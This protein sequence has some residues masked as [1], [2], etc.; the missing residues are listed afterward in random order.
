MAKARGFTLGLQPN[1]CDC[2]SE[3]VAESGA[4]D[5]F[6]EPAGELE[7]RAEA[8]PNA[9]TDAGGARDRAETAD[10][11]EFRMEVFATQ[12]P[13]LGKADLGAAA[14][15]P[16]GRVPAERVV[17]NGWIERIDVVRRVSQMGGRNAG[18]D[19]G[20]THSHVGADTP[21]CGEE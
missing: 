3:L 18:A 14:D 1:R 15:N 13:M 11:A 5:V 21:D 12:Q 4:H 8:G 20:E 19:V 7:C 2:R 16:A 17:R 10:A 6:G 9:I